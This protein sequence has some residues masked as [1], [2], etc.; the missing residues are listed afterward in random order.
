[1]YADFL[2]YREVSQTT[3]L[4]YLSFKCFACLLLRSLEVLCSLE[5]L[6]LLEGHWLL[7]LLC[8]LEI[9]WFLCWLRLVE[10]LYKLKLLWF[11]EV[12]NSLEML[13]SLKE[14]VVLLV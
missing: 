11:F 9:V 10:V 1:M 4:R 7:R 14:Y 6:G 5:V 2:L 13:C 12:L 3:T 8:T